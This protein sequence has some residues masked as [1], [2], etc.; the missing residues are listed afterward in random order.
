MKRL[1][2]IVSVLLLV[3]LS[4]SIVGCAQPSQKVL[5]IFSYHPEYSWVVEETKGAEDILR[6]KGV[7]TEKFYLDTKRNTSTD[8][9]K[10]V[11]EAAVE[12]I[13][14]FKPDVVIVFDDNACELVA[15]KYIDKSLQNRMP[16][17]SFMTVCYCRE[18]A[19]SNRPSESAI[20]HSMFFPEWRA[21][22]T[23]NCGYPAK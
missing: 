6:D 22:I 20:L 5:L 1:Y 12:K 17:S 7:E 9:K 4:V 21:G 14:E 18:S 23:S 19:T 3:S 10:K 11:A 16:I 8:W 2:F 13:G 15:K